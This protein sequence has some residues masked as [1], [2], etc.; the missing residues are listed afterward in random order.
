LEVIAMVVDVYPPVGV[1]AT[2]SVQLPYGAMVGVRLAQG[3]LP[4]VVTLNWGEVT[5]IPETIRSA[6]PEFDRVSC[7]GIDVLPMGIFPKETEAGE[8]EIVGGMPTQSNVAVIST[9]AFMVTVQVPVPEHPPPDQPA[10]TEPENGWAVRVTSVPS[11]KDDEQLGPQ[12][13]PAG[14]LV[15]SPDPVPA[16]TTV[17]GYVSTPVPLNIVKRIGDS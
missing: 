5:V 7:A 2:I 6:L 8:R 9:G 3:A 11:G 4:P 10:K 17:S 15:T 16:N 1:K 12:C 14:G 13:I